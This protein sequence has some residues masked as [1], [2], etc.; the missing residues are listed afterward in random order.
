MK[1]IISAFA[2]ILLFVTHSTAGESNSTISL[3]QRIHFRIGEKLM[4]L[5][6]IE[7]LASKYVAERDPE[8]KKAAPPAVFYVG[9]S[10][11]DFVTVLYST[12]LGKPYWQI[13]IGTKG[14]ITSYRREIA[15]DEVG[16]NIKR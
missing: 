13:T 10:K 3:S 2:A 5:E 1:T 8:F 11:K 14:Q 7:S 16:G 9:L 4:S 6:E 15:R 12:Q